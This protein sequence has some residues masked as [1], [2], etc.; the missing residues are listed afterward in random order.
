MIEAESLAGAAAHRHAV[1][2]MTQTLLGYT[3]QKGYGGI[4]A[5]LVIYARNGSQGIGK[6]R[7]LRSRRVEECIDGCGGAEFLFL[8]ESELLQ[9]I[10]ER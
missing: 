8:I 10:N 3:Y 2:G 1:D 6:T 5:A 7:K 4:G 9:R